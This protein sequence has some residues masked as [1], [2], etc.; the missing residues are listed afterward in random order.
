MRFSQK[1][2]VS[3]VFSLCSSAYDR[4][5][6]LYTHRGRVRMYELGRVRPCITVLD[7]YDLYLNR[8][9]GMAIAF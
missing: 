5:R 8:I 6:A 1:H 3:Y 4:T 7:H 9:G 2:L